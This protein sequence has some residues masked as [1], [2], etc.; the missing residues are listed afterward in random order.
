VASGEL[1]DAEWLDMDEIDLNGVSVPD[2][3]MESGLPVVDVDCLNPGNPSVTVWL[4]QIF[5]YLF[6]QIFS[7][8][9]CF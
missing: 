4:Q 7:I 9:G 5:T 8:I 3:R 1:E 6:H 2:S